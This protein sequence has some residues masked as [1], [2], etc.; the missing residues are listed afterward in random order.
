MKDAINI[1]CF[2]VKHHYIDFMAAEFS[3][4]YLATGR[5]VDV[6]IWKQDKRRMFL[7]VLLYFSTF[8]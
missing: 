2:Q 8:S 7:P 4:A 6:R 1:S 5:G 3:T